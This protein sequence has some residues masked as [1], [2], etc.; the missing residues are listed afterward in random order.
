M[1]RKSEVSAEARQAL[2]TWLIQKPGA[3]IVVAAIDECSDGALNI[4]TWVSALTGYHLL[5]LMR[6]L[7]DQAME[8]FEETQRIEVTPEYERLLKIKELL[9][10]VVAT[11]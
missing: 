2:E 6:A 8:G 10:S 3:A 9:D 4:A 11:E 1:R 5:A 7:L